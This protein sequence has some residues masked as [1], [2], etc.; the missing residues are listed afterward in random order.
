MGCGACLI[1]F[2]PDLIAM[3]L[4]AIPTALPEVLILEP[5]VFGDER[6]FFYES[7]NAKD[8]EAATGSSHAFVQDN[9]SR[10]LKNV[11]RGLHYQVRQPQGKLVRVT[12]GEIFDVA[13]DI[14]RQSPN[15]G[16]WVGVILSAE[17]KRQLWIPEGFAHG[18]VVISE[19]AD[20][21]YKTT[22]YWHPEYERAIAWNDSQLSIVWPIKGDVIVSAKDAAASLLENAEVFP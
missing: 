17:N 22:A 15:F 14:R 19:Q 4:I 12:A 13:V 6:G 21:L 18:F 5:R 3:G 2:F 10:S 9:H 8:F 7:F 1:R 20:F 11:V 16:R